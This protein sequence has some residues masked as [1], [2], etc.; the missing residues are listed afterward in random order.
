MRS[1]ER[2]YFALWANDINKY[3]RAGYNFRTL[4]EMRDALLEYV[5]VDQDNPI[6]IDQLDLIDLLHMTGL[7][8]DYNK[9]PFPFIDEVKEITLDYRKGKK[10]NTSFLH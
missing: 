1:S 3:L 10:V 9:T 2:L 6:N 7:Q 4:S 8:L 5:S